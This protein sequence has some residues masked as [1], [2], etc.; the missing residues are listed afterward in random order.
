MKMTK[1]NKANNN[2]NPFPATAVA[3]LARGSKELLTI[4]TPSLKKLRFVIYDYLVRK[5]DNG[6]TICVIGEY[7]TGKTHLLLEILNIIY[8][9]NDNKL[10][11]FYLDAP[12]D[13]FLELYKRRFIPKL[14]RNDI[15]ERLNECFSDVVAAEL[16]EDEIYRELSQKLTNREI[17]P[18]Y[19]IETVGLMESKLQRQFQ[20]RLKNI[21]DDP[22]F[23]LALTL[24]QNPEFEDAIWAWFCGKEPEKAI[25]ERGI[26]QIIDTNEMALEAIGVLAYLFGRQGH[27][28]ILLIDELEKVFSSSSGHYP[29]QAS[30]LAFKKLFEAIGKT[31]ALLVL[32]GLPEFYESLP[33][34]AVQRISLKIEPS[35]L[36][37]RDIINYIRKANK[38][39]FDK[40]F[41]KPFSKD[42]AKY[43]SITLLSNFPFN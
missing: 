31:G 8:G 4:D 15:I 36:T 42:A 13:N 17:S 23:S 2:I 9:T 10:H 29:N 35:P 22:C 39:T 27:R 40:A 12:S 34:D 6:K 1:Q 11:A 16:K 7:G 20:E 3:K 18:D 33:E 25:R 38:I 30:I 14:N 5:D 32:S 28:F 41:L 43:I 24:F 21:T 37:E 26:T 19:V